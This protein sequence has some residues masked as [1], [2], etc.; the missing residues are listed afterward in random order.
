[1]KDFVTQKEIKTNISAILSRPLMYASTVESLYVQIDLLI[2]LLLKNEQEHELYKTIQQDLRTRTFDKE[3]ALTS[4]HT[5]VLFV[6]QQE[7]TA[8][9]AYESAVK[10]LRQV[11]EELTFQVSLLSDSRP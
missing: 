10:F 3:L 9:P 5:C 7:K 6:K 2:N 11:F 8:E 1:M 4:F